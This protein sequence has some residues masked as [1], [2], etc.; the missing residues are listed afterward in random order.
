MH[1]QGKKRGRGV[2]VRTDK[3]LKDCVIPGEILRLPLLFQNNTVRQIHMVQLDSGAQSMPSGAGVSLSLISALFWLTL[4]LG[5]LSPHDQQ[6]LLICSGLVFK[7]Q[8]QN[9]ENSCPLILRS[10]FVSNWV[11]CPSLNSLMPPRVMCHGDWLR[12]VSHALLK[13]SMEAHLDLC[14]EREGNFLRALLPEKHK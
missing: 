10:T 12:F 5:G 1:G 7:S 11:R 3:N 4:T 14:A 13:L 6:Q 9:S 8:M 2:T